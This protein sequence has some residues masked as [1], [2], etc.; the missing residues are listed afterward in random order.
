MLFALVLAVGSGVASPVEASGKYAAYISWNSFDGGEYPGL[1]VWVFRR[2]AQDTPVGLRYI[3][4]CLERKDGAAY[5][6]RSCKKTDRH[7]AVS[8]LLYEGYTYRI[9][10]PATAYHFSN[11]SES[12]VARF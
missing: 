11:R 1:E 7:G 8:W 3:K 12:F 10:V 4:V 2:D 9:H 5:H 6:T